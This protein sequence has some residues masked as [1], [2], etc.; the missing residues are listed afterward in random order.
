MKQ[1]SAIR[2]DD[3]K[4]VDDVAITGDLFRMERMD[5]GVWWVCIYRGGVRTAFNLSSKTA[6]EATVLE[7][8][9]GCTDDTTRP[10]DRQP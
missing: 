7:D 5:D 4:A 3:N 6:I 8:S 9:I 1:F 10:G 2:L